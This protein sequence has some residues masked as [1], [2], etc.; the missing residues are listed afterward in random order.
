M[1]AVLET[2]RELYTGLGYR[3]AATSAT[4]EGVTE[5]LPHLAGR[6]SVLAGP[7]G[8]GKS[9]LVNALQPGLR[10]RAAEVSEKLRRGRHTTRHAQLFAIDRVP[11]AL[12]ADTPGF[13]FVEFDPQPPRDPKTAL[14]EWAQGRGLPLPSYREVGRDGPPHAP[15]F[16]M[17]VAVRGRTPAHGSGKTKREAER[18]AA[19][20]MLDALK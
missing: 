19:T 18:A 13:S 20:A 7:S 14:Q 2:L 6:L 5:L 9:S 8:V 11:G 17:E 1:D 10:L 16:I 4:P 12:L 15:Q 3:V